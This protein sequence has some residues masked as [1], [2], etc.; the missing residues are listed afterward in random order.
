MGRSEHSRKAERVHESRR[1]TS[2]EKRET[3][4]TMVEVLIRKVLRRIVNYKQTVSGFGLAIKTGMPDG[5]PTS[6]VVVVFAVVTAATDDDE[7][8]YVGSFITSFNPRRATFDAVVNSTTGSSCRSSRKIVEKNR[9]TLTKTGRSTEILFACLSLS[10]VAP[11]ADDDAGRFV[12]VKEPRCGSF[13]VDMQQRARNCLTRFLPITQT[14]WPTGNRYSP[15]AR[16]RRDPFSRSL[17]T[18]DIGYLSSLNIFLTALSE[19]RS[20]RYKFFKRATYTN[21]YFVYGRIF[22]TYRFAWND[23]FLKIP[24]VYLFILNTIVK[25]CFSVQIS[26]KQALAGIKYTIGF[27]YS[28]NPFDI[29]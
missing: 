12:F 8:Y 25:I 19:T 26:L 18:L 7:D 11:R 6:I 28:F 20:A 2:R 15:S 29:G 13:K 9:R 21:D 4:E 14:H 5:S 16:S 3:R 17:L 10:T 24:T 1:K 22:R 23:S 27:H